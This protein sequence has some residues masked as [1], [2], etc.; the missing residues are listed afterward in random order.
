MKN[1]KCSQKWGPRKAETDGMYINHRAV[2]VFN[3]M[4]AIY[5]KY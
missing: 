2:P 3:I 1:M 4:V 5:I